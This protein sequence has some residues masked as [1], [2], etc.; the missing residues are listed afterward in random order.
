MPVDELLR[1]P[2]ACDLA[3]KL[4]DCYRPAAELFPQYLSREKRGA[5]KESA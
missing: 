4:T 3:P 1:R 2:D 5:T